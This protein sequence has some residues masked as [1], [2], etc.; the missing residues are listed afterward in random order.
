MMSDGTG[1]VLLQ[2]QAARVLTYL[3]TTA[4]I[5]AAAADTGG[6]YSMIEFTTP[7]GPVVGPPAHVHPHS[8]AFYVLEGSMVFLVGDRREAVE[9]G[10]FAYVPGG[11]VHTFANV[12]VA[13]AR[14]LTIF[15][16]GGFETYFEEVAA[17]LQETAGG[18]PDMER[19]SVVAR[20]HG[21]EAIGPPLQV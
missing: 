15:A 16:P 12:G 8:E 14:F 20:K 19:L 9:A 21:Q 10:A 1:D 3:G 7:V 13:P 6:A 4:A 2:P 5:R 18:P 11:V 17:L